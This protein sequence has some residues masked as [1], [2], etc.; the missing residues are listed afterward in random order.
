[1]SYDLYLIDPITKEVL[2]LE[3]PHQ[4][5]GGTYAVGGTTQCHLNITYNYGTHYY[6]IFGEEGIKILQ[7]KMGAETISILRDGANKLKDDVCDD[8][9]E[10]TEGNAK[11][12]LLQLIALAQMRPDGIWDIH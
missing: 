6:K 8:Y 3:T 4:M 1:M 7:D 12:A 9:W 5:K 10:A 2:E 11:R